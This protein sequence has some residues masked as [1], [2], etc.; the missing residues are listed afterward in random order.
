MKRGPAYRNGPYS[1]QNKILR[2]VWTHYD[3]WQDGV[4]GL[5]I[6][7]DTPLGGKRYQVR[8]LDNPWFCPPEVIGKRICWVALQINELQ[9]RLYRMT[10]G[11]LP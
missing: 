4:H 10:Y 5:T 9:A 3:A 2:N 7:G 8:I 1:Y 6:T 11:S